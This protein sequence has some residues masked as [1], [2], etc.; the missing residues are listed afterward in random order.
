MY[1]ICLGMAQQ[2]IK[3]SYMVLDGPFKAK[4]NELIEAGYKA[5]T[6]SSFMLAY[7]CS[8]KEK[9]E[10]F[11]SHITT[12]D[13]I[14]SPLYGDNP[15]LISDGMSILPYGTLIP[16][17]K[18]TQRI[19][20]LQKNDYQVVDCQ[21]L[22]GH[23]L[24]LTH[25]LESGLVKT[26]VPYDDVRKSFAEALSE[27]G[28]DSIDFAVGVYDGPILDPVAIPITMGIVGNRLVISSEPNPERFGDSYQDRVV[29][30]KLHLPDLF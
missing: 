5:M 8:F 16:N 26:L 21:I 11:G 27:N 13:F 22:S 7:L 2:G 17:G 19:F 15:S 29:G 14:F 30:T 18:K 23:G 3:T 25:G 12:L 28:V 20:N 9:K 4:V 10:I 24:S 1:K 6:V